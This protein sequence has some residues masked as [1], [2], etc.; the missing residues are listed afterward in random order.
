MR[1]RSRRLSPELVDALLERRDLPSLPGGL[2]AAAAIQQSQAGDRNLF[3]QNGINGLVL[4]RTFVNRLN[5]RL[6]T[7]KDQ[8]ARVNQAFQV[9]A[10]NYKALPVSPPPGTTG[11]TLESLVMA[12]KQQVAVA[13]I[14]RQGLSSQMT[15]SELTSIRY[16]PLAPVALVP[17]A[18]GQIDAMAATL[19][20]LPPVAGPD[21]KLTSGNPTPAVNV[22]V[23][24]ILNALAESTVH[25]L[26]FLKPESFYL[27]PNI[28][29]TLEFSGAPAASAPGFFI[30]GPHG[31]IL[32]GATLHPHAPN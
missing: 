10:T 7:S 28:Q 4:H 14:R 2:Q 15:V 5:D 17:F 31:A 6:A 16:S 22:A 20:E 19:A 23:N 32:P 12:L 3:H 29:F 26:L 13:L 30:R 1:R 25:P 27:N 24:G 21:G 18:S 11:P 9:F 8:T